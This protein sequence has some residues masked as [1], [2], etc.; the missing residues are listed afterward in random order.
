MKRQRTAARTDQQATNERT[1]ERTNGPIVQVLLFV[2][3]WG[4]YYINISQK[5]SRYS[6]T[7][8]YSQAQPSTVMLDYWTLQYSTGTRLTV[9]Q[10][11]LQ[12]AQ[13]QSPKVQ[14]KHYCTNLI[15]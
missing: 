3:D 6:S 13:H 1:N 8:K 15:G 4:L 14:D 2:I 11:G 7:V 10:S 12:Y 9:L 5:Y